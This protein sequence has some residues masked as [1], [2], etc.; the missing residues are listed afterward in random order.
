MKK[1]FDVGDVINYQGVN[2]KVGNVEL[3][4]GNEY[5]SPREDYTFLIVTIYIVNNTNKSIDY[6]YTNWVMTDDDNVEGKKVF[7]SINSDDALYSGRLKAGSTKRGS[8]IFEEPKNAKKIRLSFYDLNVD[9]NGIKTIN[10]DKKAFSINI[11][12]PQDS[13]KN[14]GM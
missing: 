14:K 9:E 8:I 2:Y 1:L 11:D 10:K 3:S 12:M 6:G 13:K 5:K 4:N 7:S